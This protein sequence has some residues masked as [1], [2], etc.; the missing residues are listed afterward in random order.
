ML[1]MLLQ[2][3]P[4]CPSLPYLRAVFGMVLTE[5]TIKSHPAPVLKLWQSPLP[6]QCCNSGV[7]HGASPRCFPYTTVCQLTQP[8]VGSTARDTVWNLV[9][10]AALGS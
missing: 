2:L 10:Q 9:R 7:F 4:L 1:E 3:N 8:F 5:V 6:V